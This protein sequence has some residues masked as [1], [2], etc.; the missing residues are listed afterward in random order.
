M[1]RPSKRPRTPWPDGLTRR[2]VVLERLAMAVG[3]GHPLAGLGEPA[4]DASSCELTGRIE[5][6]H[7]N[8]WRLLGTAGTAGCRGCR[9]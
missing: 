1:F 4:P 2:P 5:L 3:D 9:D 8:E 6:T 7:Y